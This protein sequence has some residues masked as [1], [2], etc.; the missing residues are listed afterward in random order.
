[1][2]TLPT[3]LTILMLMFG[4]IAAS[5]QTPTAKEILQKAEEKTRGTESAYSELK[6]TTVRP[7]WTREMTMKSWAKGNDFS[8]ILITGPARD[9][10][11]AFLKRKKEVWNWVPNIERTIKMP[12]SMMMQSWMGTDFTNDDLVRESSTVNDYNSEI[13]GDSTI[14]GRT[15]WKLRLIPKPDAPVV[16][17]KVVV[18]IDQ[19]DYIQLRTESYDEDFYLV[20]VMN[21]S[22][23]KEVDG[24]T[25]ATKME[26]I[27]QDKDGH[28][29]L[30]EITQMQFNP[31]ISEDFFTTQNMKRVK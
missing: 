30:M 16:W 2:K 24:Q 26:M 25:I 27:P 11:T 29:T 3:V 13:V 8:L 10:G 1:M 5:A 22:A 18:F 20:N 4:S 21:A 12:P 7:R 14:A 31:D 15:C 17:G 9:K 23:I 6:I 28:K 19:Q